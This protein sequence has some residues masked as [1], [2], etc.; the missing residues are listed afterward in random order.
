M[1]ASTDLK[2]YSFRDVWHAILTEDSFNYEFWLEITLQL[3]FTQMMSVFGRVLVLIVVVLISFLAYVGFFVAL[4]LNCSRGSF[5][6]VFHTFNGIFLLSNILFNYIC[7]VTTSPGHPQPELADVI[8]EGNVYN[9]KHC[10]KC[11]LPKPPRAHHCSIC[12]RC[13]LRMDHHCPYISNW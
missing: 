8:E 7:A 9:F 5:L 13:V 6:S 11:N 1:P 4:P 2:R 3:V 12:K 10:K